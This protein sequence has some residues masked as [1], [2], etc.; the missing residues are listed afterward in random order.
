MLERLGAA[1]LSTDAV[2]HELYES[3]EVRDAVVARWGPEVAPGG[4]VDRTAV[5]RHAFADPGE[6]QW[7]EALLW[8]LVG[9]RVAE[10]LQA[11]AGR[12][13]T[14]VAAVVEIPLL[15]ES[16]MDGAFHATIAVVASEAVRQ[17]RAAERGHAAVDER[18]ARQLTQDEKAARATFAIPNDASVADL[19]AQLAA[20][21]DKLKG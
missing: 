15:F 20:V 9:E 18:T 14:P 5:A 17:A 6:R 4:A 11:A 2:V 16:G 3:D 1:T 13:P 8:P 10:F 12:E 19:Q 7:L 21:L